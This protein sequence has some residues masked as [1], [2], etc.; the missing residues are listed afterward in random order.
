MRLHI[1]SRISPN[2]DKWP[3]L[4][5]GASLLLGS[6]Q[7]RDVQP[8]AP[9]W[10]GHAHGPEGQ[11]LET[12]MARVSGPVGSPDSS[13]VHKRNMESTSLLFCN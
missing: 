9:Y 10:R 11:G 2:E 4:S 12:G 1:S 6:Q 7:A 5:P 3:G 13:P 8:P